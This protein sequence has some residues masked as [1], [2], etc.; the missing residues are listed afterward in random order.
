M[1]IKKDLIINEHIENINRISDMNIGDTISRQ[2]AIDDIWTVS[3]LVPLDHEWI[4]RWLKQLP[5]A[6]PEIIRCK[7]CKHFDPI[8]TGGA[9]VCE[10]WNAKTEEDIYCGYAEKNEVMK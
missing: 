6:Q 10:H 1:D 5:S 3:P 4:D 8:Y 7:D 9:G 2:Q